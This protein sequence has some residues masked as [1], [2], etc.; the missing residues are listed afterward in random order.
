MRTHPVYVNLTVAIDDEVLERGRERAKRLGTSVQEVVRRHLEEFGGL[1]SSVAAADELLRLLE[2]H[3]GN[4][5]GQRFLRDDI[6]SG[7]V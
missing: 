1:G 3:P 5:G 7:R 2:E 6:Y 4:S